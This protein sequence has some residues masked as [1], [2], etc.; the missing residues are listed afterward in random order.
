MIRHGDMPCQFHVL[1]SPVG[2]VALPRL[3]VSIGTDMGIGMRRFARPARVAG[4][5]F[6]TRG[7]SGWFVRRATGPLG[8]AMRARARTRSKYTQHYSSSAAAA[9]VRPAGSVRGLVSLPARCA[10]STWHVPTGKPRCAALRT[11]VRTPTC[12]FVSTTNGSD[13][14]PSCA[15]SRLAN[16][17]PNGC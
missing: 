9:A 17:S 13:P 15:E 1:P 6:T 16:P 12:F 8:C 3:F 10:R 14:D 7:S 11:P 4:A 2:L 5:A